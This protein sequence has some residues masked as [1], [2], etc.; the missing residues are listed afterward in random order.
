[1][2]GS[3]QVVNF[4]NVITHEYNVTY[5]CYEYYKNYIEITQTPVI[6]TPILILQLDAKFK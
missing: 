4:R 6:I 1:M 3:I 5:E 2:H